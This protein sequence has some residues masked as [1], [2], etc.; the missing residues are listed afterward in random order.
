MVLT[1]NPFYILEVNPTDH[2]SCIQ[3]ACERKSLLADEMKCREAEAILIHPQRRLRAELTWL[4]TVSTSDVCA[5]CERMPA[6]QQEMADVSMRSFFVCGHMSDAVAVWMEIVLLYN[7]TVHSVSL[8]KETFITVSCRLAEYFPRVRCGELISALNTLR[9]VAGMPL[10]RHDTDAADVIRE[11][12]DE[13]SSRMEET[14]RRFSPIDQREIITQIVAAATNR[15]RTLADESV[16]R[17]TVEYEQARQGETLSSD[18]GIALWMIEGMGEAL[19]CNLCNEQKAEKLM[20]KLREWGAWYRPLRWAAQSRGRKGPGED[21]LRSLQATIR[22]LGKAYGQAE[23]ALRFTEIL[24]E[25]CAPGAALQTTLQ[26]DKA[27]FAAQAARERDMRTGTLHLQ[28]IAYRYVSSV[29]NAA[30]FD[31]DRTVQSVNDTTGDSRS[32]NT[33][34]RH[35]SYGQSATRIGNRCAAVRTCVD[36][37][38]NRTVARQNINTTVRENRNDPTDAAPQKIV[39]GAAP[40]HR[41]D[42]WRNYAWT[43]GLA[44]IAVLL[45][46][47]L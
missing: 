12:Y 21:T 27:K 38:R 15:G 29:E 30:L 22:K 44:I 6:Q 9:A 20:Q 18:L 31:N 33:A 16:Y 37:G 14:F 17:L 36:N 25:E 34:Y 47:L 19:A 28:S 43:I 24:L 35:A 13:I 23:T 3:M 2:A 7:L 41:R 32:M 4:F 46:L 1:D 40:L 45:I 10:I 11:Y 42:D 8:A 39:D 5:W 26:A